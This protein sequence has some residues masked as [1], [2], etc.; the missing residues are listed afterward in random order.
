MKKIYNIFIIALTFLIVL[1]IPFVSAA[2]YVVGIV[3]DARDGTTVNG[4]NLVLWNPARGI[5]DNQTDIIGLNGNS[6]IDNVY[7]IDCE[8]LQNSCNI[9]NTLKVR[10]LDNGDGR[11]SYDADIIVTG[12][13]Y[14]IAPELTLNSFPNSS[15]ISP[16]NNANLSSFDTVFNCSA[17]D[18]DSNLNSVTLYGNWSIGWHANETKSISGGSSYGVFTKQIP[19]GNYIWSCLASDNLSLSTFSNNNFSFTIDRTPPSIGEIQINQSS[20]CGTTSHIRVNCSSYDSLLGISSVIIQA[21]KPH[22]T[23]NYSTQKISNSYYSDILADVEGTWKFNCI[24][25]DSAGN[26][27]NLTSIDFFV[28][29]ANP[30]LQISSEMINFSDYSPIENNEVFIKANISNNGCGDA[31]NLLVGF[32]NGDPDSGGTQIGNKTVSIVRFN[33][34]SVNFSW[35]PEIGTSNIFV[36][37]DLN[38]S[39]DEMNESDNKANNTITLD[40]WQQFFG[41]VSLNKIISDSPLSNM[42]VWINAYKITGN[43]FMSNQGSNVNWNN[44]QAFGKNKAGGNSNNDFLNAD[45]LLGMSNFSDSIYKIYTN[46][47][48]VD[49][50]DNFT[51]FNKDISFVP[52]VNSTNNSNFITGI[53]WDTTRDTNGYFDLSDKEPLVFITKV[54]MKKQGAYGIYDYEFRIPALLRNYNSTENRVYLYYELT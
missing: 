18:V 50:T 30:D 22:G 4:R 32:Y 15:I 44:M 41:N 40:S 29:T 5:N 9:G 45:L 27:A 48:Q 51:V 52:I 35:F 12:A 10:V 2:H 1:V 42:S 24:A 21:I 34:G 43:I 33:N 3:N 19:E 7:M 6:G 17:T 25:N 20:V 37:V 36:I 54:N 23:Q 26:I 38:S 46:N 16:L 8:L 31:S 39:I 53:L 13:G 49:K 47:G 28:Y 11:V 14:D